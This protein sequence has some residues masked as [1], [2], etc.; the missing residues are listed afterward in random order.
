MNKMYPTSK[1]A[2]KTISSNKTFRT[3]MAQTDIWN[4]GSQITWTAVNQ[5]IMLYSLNLA[6][7]PLQS[8]RAA[9]TEVLLS[10]GHIGFA[11]LSIDRK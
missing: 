4:T 10:L 1:T 2:I 9:E 11:P 6:F 8:L 3:K 7:Y 5:L